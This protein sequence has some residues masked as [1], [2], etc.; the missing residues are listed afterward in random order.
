MAIELRGYQRDALLAVRRDWREGHKRCLVSMP[1]GTG[2]TWIFVFAIYSARANGLRCL[3]LVNTD[4][5]LDQ[6]VE[7]LRKVGV[8]PGVIKGSKNEWSRDVVVA[9]VQTLSRASRLYNL[10]PNHFGLIIT[11]EAHY[12]NAPSYQRVL[13]YFADAWHL[14]VTATPFR[15]DKKSLAGA[16]W[17]TVSYVY[18]MQQAIKEK[19][20]APVRFER[21]NTGVELKGLT[22]SGATLTSEKDFNAKALSKLINTDA[23]NNAIVDAAISKLVVANGPFNKRLRRTIAF[24]ADVDHSICLANAFRRRGIEAYAVYGSMKTKH[25]AAIVKAHKMGRY[26]ILTNCNILTT[27][28]DDPAIEGIIMARPTESKVLYLQCLGRGLRLSPETGKA[29]CVALD[30]VDVAKKHAMTIGA[31]LIELEEQLEEQGNTKDIAA[32]ITDA[33]AIPGLLKP[34]EP[35]SLAPPPSA[36][37]MEA[38]MPGL[39]PKSEQT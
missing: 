13:W 24:C 14:G 7:K 6:T 15:G 37:E 35:P 30:V 31:E 17:N 8:D 5:L 22:K 12:A 18:T 21:V 19:W 11:D 10:P 23:R 3:V 2:K 33:S 20:L 26:P 1:T 4:E 39:V 16:G 9:S 32:P 38:Q 36:E 28:Y 27:G 29:D 25:R 34:A